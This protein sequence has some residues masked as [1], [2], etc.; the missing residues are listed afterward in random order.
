MM[1]TF[2]WSIQEAIALLGGYRPASEDKQSS[3]TTSSCRDCEEEE[4][5]QEG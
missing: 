5:F 4:E 3:W 1:R 2:P